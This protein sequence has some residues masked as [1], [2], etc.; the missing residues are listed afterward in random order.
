MV[1]KLHFCE[2]VYFNQLLDFTILF[3]IIPSLFIIVSLDTEFFQYHQV[4]NSLDQDQVLCFVG[5]DL[6]PNC[7]QRFSADGKS[8]H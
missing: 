5:P 6:G 4:S 7:L 2:K 1:Q 3:F 8:C